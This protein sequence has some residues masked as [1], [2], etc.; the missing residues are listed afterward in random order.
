MFVF[1]G[2]FLFFLIFISESDLYVLE[3]LSDRLNLSGGFEEFELANMIG[4]TGTL[5]AYYSILILN[6]GDYSRYVKDTKELT[7]GNI[8]LAFSLILFSLFVLVIIVGSDTYFRSN[9]INISMV[10]TNPTDIIGKLNKY[11]YL[12]NYYQ[13]WIK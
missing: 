1:F 8:S 7:K 5:F 3:T 9:N 2:L 11:R 10:L 12:K 13:Y 4:I 6:F